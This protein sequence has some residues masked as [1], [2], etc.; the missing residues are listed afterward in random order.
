LATKSKKEADERLFAVPKTVDIP[1]TKRG[2][3]KCFGSISLAL[4]IEA[5][6]KVLM[7]NARAVYQHY[8]VP[9]ICLAARTPSGQIKHARFPE[10]EVKRYQLGW[11]LIPEDAAEELQMARR[12]AIEV[13]TALLCL[14]DCNERSVAIF[15]GNARDAMAR[16]EILSM[17]KSIFTARKLLRSAHLGGRVRT[18]YDEKFQERRSKILAGAHG[19]LQKHPN[20]TKNRVSTKLAESKLG[21]KR[22]IARHLFKK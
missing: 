13:E 22:N 1:I 11:F 8:N 19:Y 5:Q 20:A 6:L 10:A 4:N 18:L 17:K 21:S 16:L 3:D 9:F 15:Y 14:E 7:R 12:L 2:L